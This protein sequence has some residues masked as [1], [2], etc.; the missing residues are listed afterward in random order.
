MSVGDLSATFAGPGGG[1]DALSPAVIGSV[2]GAGAAADAVGAALGG[3]GIDGRELNSTE[4]GALVDAIMGLVAP[5]GLL[6]SPFLDR[7]IA[8]V[9]RD[10][11]NGDAWGNLLDATLA[12]IPTN[13]SSSA[14]TSLLEYNGPIPLPTLDEFILVHQIIRGIFL[15]NGDIW[16]IY[17]ARH[18]APSGAEWGIC[19]RPIHL[20]RFRIPPLP[21]GAFMHISHL[22]TL[23]I[24]QYSWSP[25]RSL[26]TLK[27][28]IGI[29]PLG[30]IVELGGVAFVPDT[31]AVRATAQRMLA[32]S[33]LFGNHYAGSYPTVSAAVDAANAVDVASGLWAVVEFD[34]PPPATAAP[35]AQ[36][37]RSVSFKIRLKYTVMP[38]AFAF[39]S[40]HALPRSLC[41]L[42]QRALSC[43]L[44]RHLNPPPPPQSSPHS[45]GLNHQALTRRT[46]R[47]TPAS[48]R[49]TRCTSPP[50]SPH[51]SAPS[52]RRCAPRMIGAT[53]T[54]DW[55]SQLR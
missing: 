53:R 37:Q 48:A 18:N 21:R 22:T 5:V 15:R 28:Q 54:N 13:A 39:W 32:R 42:Q 3:G 27:G 26:Q 12:S 7:A 38:G 49:A 33:A 14:F 1:L 19:T 20:L 6:R 41:S 47:T 9:I 52:P 36:Q 16:A 29:N 43:V 31:P 10:P 17:K 2:L 23:D 51:Y 25:F 4:T 24:P 30:N 11:S 34:L 35:A 46:T 50:A 44:L 55:N 45:F 40:N 8:G